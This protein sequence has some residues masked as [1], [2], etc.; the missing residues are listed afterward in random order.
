MG[1][2]ADNE[3]YQMDEHLENSRLNYSNLDSLASQLLRKFTIS[4]VGCVLTKIGNKL[5]RTLDWSQVLK[6]M[7]SKEEK[8]N[9]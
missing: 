3:K 6:L 8:I 9:K 2:I 1:K 5:S 7:F 4:K